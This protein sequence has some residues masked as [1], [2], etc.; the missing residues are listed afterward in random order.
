MTID[1]RLVANPAT[2]SVIDSNRNVKPG[3]L[4]IFQI[5]AEITIIKILENVNNNNPVCIYH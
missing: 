2:I 4:L 5:K 3:I 1:A